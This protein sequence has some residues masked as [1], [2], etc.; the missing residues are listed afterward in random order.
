ISA[1]TRAAWSSSQTY[2]VISD[3]IMLQRYLSAPRTLRRTTGPALRVLET[4]FARDLR[5]RGGQRIAPDLE[6]GQRGDRLQP[7]ELVDVL[8]VEDADAGPR[9]ANDRARVERSEQSA[10]GDH[11]GGERGGARDSERPEADAAP[12]RNDDRPAHR[13]ERGRAK[14]PGEG[15]SVEL[16]RLAGFAEQ[17]MAAQ[18]NRF[19]IGQL[20]VELG[21][22]P[23]A[24]AVDRKSTR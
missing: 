6:L 5:G 15:R 20:S 10:R 7:L 4:R 17:E 8:I 24:R 13:L 3:G 14:R 12:A 21:R 18:E 19:E 11:H 22:D 1:A 9:L 16:E 23:R 2:E